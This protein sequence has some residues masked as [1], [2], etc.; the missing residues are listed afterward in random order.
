MSIFDTLLANAAT[1]KPGSKEAIA[2]AQKFADDF[3]AL[4]DV[5]KENI[6]KQAKDAVAN[7]PDLLANVNKSKVDAT[8][9]AFQTV[10]RAVE[11][12]DGRPTNTFPQFSKFRANTPQEHPDGRFGPLT[13]AV[14]LG[15]G[16]GK[17]NALNALVARAEEREAA[18][19]KQKES[20]ERENDYLTTD[21]GGETPEQ[22]AARLK[23]EQDEAARKKAEEE[24]PLK[25]SAD[26]VARYTFTRAQVQY[27]EQI[28]KNNPAAKGS[29]T[30]EQLK[31]ISDAV[32]DYAFKD[33]AIKRENEQG[34]KRDYKSDNIQAQLRD[35]VRKH[36]VKPE[37][38]ASEVSAIEN[39]IA[40][41][42]FNVGNTKT[43]SIVGTFAATEASVENADKALSKKGDAIQ[44]YFQQG[45]NKAILEAAKIKTDKFL[46][47][48]TEVEENQRGV[49]FKAAYVP[50]LNVL[51]DDEKKK[52]TAEYKTKIDAEKA[53][54]LKYE[55]MEQIVSNGYPAMLAVT[56]KQEVIKKGF[57]A[58]GNPIDKKSTQEIKTGEVVDKNKVF[59]IT[60]DLNNK[61]MKDALVA[62]GLVDEKT[63]AIK[64][65]TYKATKLD[66]KGQPVLVDGKPVTEEKKVMADVALKDPTTY[67]DA[68]K[69]ALDEKFAFTKE[70]QEANKVKGAV[71]DK[72]I[73]RTKIATENVKEKEAVAKE[74]IRLENERD[75]KIENSP[76]RVML[77]E[78]FD[79]KDSQ[80]IADGQAAKSILGKYEEAIK[81]Y[82]DAA[83]YQT[84]RQLFEL[85][86]KG[87]DRKE[88]GELDDDAGKIE[89]SM[90]RRINAAEEDVKTLEAQLKVETDEAKKGAAQ[91]KLTAAKEGLKA[92]TDVPKKF[93][94]K[95]RVDYLEVRFKDADLVHVDADTKKE[96]K[97]KKTAATAK[98]QANTVTETND[99]QPSKEEDGKGNRKV[100]KGKE[101]KASEPTTNVAPVTNDAVANVQKTEP[102]KAIVE[103][104]GEVNALI[105]KISGELNSLEAPIEKNEFTDKKAV[106]KS[107]NAFD[108]AIKALNKDLGA[109]RKLNEKDEAVDTDFDKAVAGFRKQAEELGVVVTDDFKV[110]KQAS[111]QGIKDKNAA[112]GK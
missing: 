13:N 9:F 27:V 29:F 88:R 67:H 73:I 39:K 93:D 89:K 44:Q 51:A 28:A 8:A 43:R 100:K 23:K 77:N 30:A 54:L 80:R 53:K 49:Y 45:E 50:A 110:E 108:D 41:L 111:L 2:L 14:Y 59:S 81:Y 60:A 4:S 72:N 10:V 3:H 112:K 65:L 68:I 6:A 47:L 48:T 11:L 20:K 12:D 56:T 98:E 15:E 85:T 103:L 95:D 69:S 26:D 37:M 96:A 74:V 105:A 99:A 38:S 35:E 25:A 31:G 83:K 94:Q 34:M 40:G 62:T 97:Q 64:E 57:D 86:G 7:H 79:P 71:L 18:L 76:S 104:T 21:N 87:A 33:G 58:A 75:V 78:A 70:E 32:S 24:K 46:S 107:E 109:L 52:I 90:K 1:V 82:N 102:Q 55:F 63:G 16:N 17:V 19:A 66:E 91:A 22:K 101:T 106:K 84:K 36:L 92:L 42:T 61:A 5:E